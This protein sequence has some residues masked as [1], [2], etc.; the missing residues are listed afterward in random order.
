MPD[1][2]L[3]A[4]AAVH[5][6]LGDEHRLAIV[7]ALELSDRAPSELQ[8]LTGLPSNLLAFHL[9]ALEHAG[10]IERHRSRGDAR[11]RY[12]TLRHDVLA[13]VS[14]VPRPRMGIVLFVC[15]R[16]AARSQL[17][18]AVWTAR[19]GGRALSAGTDPAAAVHPLAIEVAADRG[20]DL[21][22]ARP[23][24]YQDVGVDPELVVSVCDRARESGL[25]FDAP[26]LHWSIPDPDGGDRAAFLA[27]FEE[28]SRRVDL[29]AERAAA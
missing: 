23:R 16:N 5:R 18:A 20:L 9:D 25:S 8:E 1:G 10:V 7:D 21:S 4:R 17:A 15:A 29:L 13:R 6:A 28:I 2:S 27:A 12:V 3:D 19:T 24:S 22:A 26:L 14:D 11:R